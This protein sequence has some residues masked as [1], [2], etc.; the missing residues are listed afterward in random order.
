MPINASA[1]AIATALLA[2]GQAGNAPA[3]VAA[4]PRAVPAEVQARRALAQSIAPSIVSVTSFIPV[5]PGAPLEGRWLEQDDSPHKGFV[6]DLTQ[7]GI[8]ISA[9]GTIICCRTPLLD[10]QGGLVELIDV[11][12]S[13][14]LRVQAEILATEPTINL[15]VLRLKPAAQ[16]D[17]A[18][19]PQQPAAPEGFV[20]ARLGSVDELQQGDPLTAVG[21]PFGAA[22]T[23]APGVVMAL[24]TA[25][26]YQ[27]DLTGSFIH[28]SMA[29]SPG[30]VG[31]AL[32]N[33]AGEVV[34]MIVPPPA[35]DGKTRLD[36]PPFT[37]YAMQI[38][39]ACGVGEALK[40]KRT[41]ESPWIGFSVLSSKELQAK[42]RDDA[43]FSEI[44][45]PPH[46]LYI[47]DIYTPSP[48]TK[49]GIQHGD[50]VMEINGLA[51]HSV[52]DFQQALYYA[53]GA[54]VPVRIFR[55]GREFTPII[56]IERRPEA[57]NR[58]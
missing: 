10:D 47:D 29:V 35:R 22:K 50:F 55:N 3:P 19:A 40:R 14:G 8:V 12:N 2:L 13:E 39:T 21:D 5:P 4:P 52:V 23:F 37:T 36:P 9:D 16:V 28:A 49:A 53:S 32:V 38:Q 18:S 15:A 24:P 45:K 46:G 48:A 1:F 33:S 25:S 58:P 27:A 6:R 42:L 51:I 17:P 41:N 54:P 34:G 30:A 7:S 57:A 26:C 44:A 43:K 31:G 11:E 56:V 20:P